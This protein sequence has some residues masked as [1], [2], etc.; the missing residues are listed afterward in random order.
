MRA[1]VCV[2]P[3]LT[4]STYEKNFEMCVGTNGQFDGPEVTV[5]GWLDVKS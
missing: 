5:C 2:S 3:L 4:G 1:C